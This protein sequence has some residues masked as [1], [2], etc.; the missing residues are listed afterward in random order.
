MLIFMLNYAHLLN[1]CPLSL[2]YDS[3]QSLIDLSVHGRSLQ[4][5]GTLYMDQT[6]NVS[7]VKLLHR[8]KNLS[9]LGNFSNKWD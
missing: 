3:S 1:L 8:T 9:I 7:V 5:S 6:Q 2:T 4:E